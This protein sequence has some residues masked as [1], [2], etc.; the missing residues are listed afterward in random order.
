LIYHFIGWI[1]GKMVTLAER[2]VPALRFILIV[3]VIVM[4]VPPVTQYWLDNVR[5]PDVPMSAIFAM[6]VGSVFMFAFAA[7][8]YVVLHFLR[9]IVLVERTTIGP[10]AT[11]A[12]VPVRS[13]GKPTEGTFITANDNML[14]AREQINEL[15]EQGILTEMD[16]MEFDELVKEMATRGTGVARTKVR[17]KI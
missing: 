17:Q 11:A 15:H 12:G 1:V 14:W 2:I 7:V 6:L 16:T 10:D 13:R 3:I 5:M 8:I 4:I 9:Q